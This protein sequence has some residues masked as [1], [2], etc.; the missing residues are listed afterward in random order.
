[1]P[2]RTRIPGA[3]GPPAR[4]FLV[5]LLAAC[6]VL[7]ATAVAATADPV[8]INGN[9]LT[10][11]VGPQGQMQA[12]LT[13]S[14]S[15]IY[16]APDDTLGDAGFFLAFPAGLGNPT[17]EDSQVFGFSGSAGPHF[18]TDYSNVSQGPVTG[19][20]SAGNPFTQVTSYA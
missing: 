8:A 6:A 4:R 5:A 19:D 14:T 15:G 16:F 3:G 7:A 18:L 13:G 12:Y 9:P 2:R 1:M 20:G 17:N 10:V 11:Y